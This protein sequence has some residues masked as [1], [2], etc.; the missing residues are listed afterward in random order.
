MAACAERQNFDIQLNFETL[1]AQ[2]GSKV[3]KG[4][5]SDRAM[6]SHE[7][8]DAHTQL[9]CTCAV[10]GSMFAAAAAVAGS[11]TSI[12]SPVQAVKCYEADR[13]NIGLAQAGQSCMA[14]LMTVCPPCCSS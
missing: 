3:S 12:A 14:N 9:Q 5:W 10:P 6:L 1:P 13:V 11:S 8:L 7:I 2:A 4:V